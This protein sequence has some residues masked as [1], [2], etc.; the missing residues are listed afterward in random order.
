MFTHSRPS[1]VWCNLPST[2]FNSI[3]LRIAAFSVDPLAAFDAPMVLIN[4]A[5]MAF[6]ADLTESDAFS[7][8]LIVSLQC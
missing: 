6:N 4:S 1:P 3:A 8:D 7:A 5:A 2:F